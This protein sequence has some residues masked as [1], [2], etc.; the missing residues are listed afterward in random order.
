VKMLFLKDWPADGVLV[1]RQDGARKKA[2]A[3]TIIIKVH[4]RHIPR[5]VVYGIR[6]GTSATN[7]TAGHTT[8]LIPARMR[9]AHGK[10]LVTVT[11]LVAGITKPSR[12]ARQKD[13]LGTIRMTT[14]TKKAAGTTPRRENVRRMPRITVPGMQMEITVMSRAAGTT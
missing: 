14:V 10:I 8:H 9:A 6:S 3:G 5:T 7:R 4:A 1:N 13:A 11:S 12:N 2:V